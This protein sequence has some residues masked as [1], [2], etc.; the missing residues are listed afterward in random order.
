MEQMV[1]RLRAGDVRALAR[2][3]LVVEAGSPGASEML[4]ACRRFLSIC[5]ADWRDWILRV[6]EEHA[7]RDHR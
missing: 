1:A 2:A 5:I 3:I 4:A 7:G 6:G